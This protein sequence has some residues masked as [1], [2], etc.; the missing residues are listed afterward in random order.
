M[1]C[2]TRI[3]ALDAAGLKTALWVLGIYAAVLTIGIAIVAV[4]VFMVS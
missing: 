4:V 1:N 2:L 3:M